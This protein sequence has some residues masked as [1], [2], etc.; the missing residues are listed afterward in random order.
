ME[1]RVL[2]VDDSAFMRRAIGEVLEAHGHKVVGRARNGVEAVELAQM[3]KPDVVTLDVEMPEM[4]GLTALPRIRRVC[5]AHV[6]MVSSLTTQGSR[7]AIAA[8]HA[9]ASDIVAKSH[10]QFTV[11]L[12]ALGA[13]LAH[14]VRGLAASKPPRNVVAAAGPAR[15]MSAKVTEAMQRVDLIAIGSSTGGPPALEAVLTALP[16][17]FA[18]AVVIAQHMPGTFTAS[19]A[20]RLDEMCKCRVLH[21]EHRMPVRP[22]FV[23]VAPGGQQLRVLKSGTGYRLEVSP[24]PKDSLY[25][26]SVN[27]LF[28]S[29]ARVCGRKALGIVLT[30]MGDDGLIGARAMHA[31]GSVILGQSYESCVVYGMPKAVSEAGLVEAELTPAEI[32]RQLASSMTQ[33]RLAS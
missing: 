7:E 13:E 16:S 5:D 26:P 14:K 10:S 29:V 22:G 2:V 8:L 15:T 24:E 19:L 11:D 18:P 32:G 20:E 27:E 28:G 6:I 3:L 21:A 4:D 31:A 17:E 33:R 30:G 1:C 25:K 23:Y 12:D 9:G